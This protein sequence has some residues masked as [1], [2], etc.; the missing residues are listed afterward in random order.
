M[1]ILKYQLISCIEGFSTGLFVYLCLLYSSL[2]T[3]HYGSII[4]VLPFIIAY[5]LSKSSL[6]L[7]EQIDIVHTPFK[8]LIILSLALLLGSF[9]GLFHNHIAY[10]LSSILIG[11]AAYSYSSIFN[12]CKSILLQK[13][14]W[15][16]EKSGLHSIYWIILLLIIFLITMQI[17]PSASFG[18]FL[19]LSLISLLFSIQLYNIDDTN[20][21]SISKNKPDHR[22]ILL[23]CII[24]FSFIFCI[25]S[26]REF[27]SSLILLAS[28]IIL[29]MFVNH[30]IKNQSIKH[31]RKITM[32]VGAIQTYL[33]L[34]HIIQ[35]TLEK[36]KLLLIS[37]YIL[38]LACLIVAI[39]LTSK[40]SFNNLI[41]I[42]I[43]GITISLIPYGNLIGLILSLFS[44]SCINN[45]LNI[46]Y[47]KDIGNFFR[48]KK[49]KDFSFGGLI[50]QLGLLITK[51]VI[52][53]I[54]FG[55]L[56]LLND[57]IFRIKHLNINNIFYFINII[58]TTVF[59]IIFLLLYKNKFNEGEIK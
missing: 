8:A 55:N 49:T 7:F 12:T 41:L 2:I 39:F 47:Q 22:N 26:L 20:C 31:Y 3:G 51:I 43:I 23:N 48:M 52:S 28:F 30:L 1:K 37:T 34:F 36:N 17:S 4:Y 58:F 46:A 29:L 19:I 35:Y 9:L 16:F 11:V 53:I 25:V 57:Y 44:I 24:F 6:V 42:L 50:A 14:K 33:I 15:P 45:Q 27:S 59:I 32:F 54:K 10:I 40:I 18:V 13:N 5:A 56:S 38:I 21:F